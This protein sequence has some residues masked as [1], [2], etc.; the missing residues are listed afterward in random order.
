[1]KI[2]TT[3]TTI[4][5]LVIMTIAFFAETSPAASTKKKKAKP[6]AKPAATAQAKTEDTSAVSLIL[7]KIE[8]R[9]DSAAFSADFNQE[10]PLPEIQVIETARGRVI[11]K[12]PGKFLWEYEKP[13]VLHYISDGET[14]W[15]YSPSDNNVW[16]GKSKEFFGKGGGAIVLADVK[17]IR[18]QFNASIEEPDNENTTKLKLV[19]KN[20]EMGLTDIFLTVDNGTYDI[21][22]IVSFNINGE[23]TRIQFRNLQFKQFSDDSAFSFKVPA[24]ANVIPLDQKM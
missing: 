7:H 3:R 24:T 15:I 16:I 19:P 14:L 17:Q 18:T 4:A 23:E 20:K 6:K 10:S 9:Y 1:M 13:E 22:K 8:N 2:F 21:I 5:C 12:K 11:F